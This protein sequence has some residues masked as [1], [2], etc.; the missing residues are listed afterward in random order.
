MSPSFFVLAGEASGD[1]HGSGLIEALLRCHPHASFFGVGGARM[2]SLPFRALWHTEKYAVMGFSEI[3]RSLPSLVSFFYQVRRAILNERP[4]HVVLIDYPGFNLRLAASL[5]KQGYQGKIIQFIAPSVWAH[6]Q[7]RIQ[8]LERY[9]DLLLTIYPFEKKHFANSTL[10]VEYVG[11]PLADAIKPQAVHSAG[12]RECLLFPGSRVGEIQRHLPTQL[13]LASMLSEVDPSLTFALSS[14]HPEVVK[15]LPSCAKQCRSLPLSLFSPAENPQ[16]M[17]SA[18]FAIAKSGTITLELALHAVPTFVHYELTRLNAWIARHCL[19]LSL[20]HYCIVN[21]I[22]ECALFPEFF[23]TQPSFDQMQEKI[24]KAYSERE[25]TR[26]ECRVIRERLDA[27]G[28][29]DRAAAAI[30]GIER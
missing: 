7:H 20:P 30:L 14:S 18:T 24:L 3:L 28:A 5:R 12:R 23:Y 1:L 21:L 2:R 15:L 19:K 22:A 27:H 11:N 17:R 13:R 25:Q 29:Y 8:T 9:Y 4:S 16:R 10:P 6:G 26:R